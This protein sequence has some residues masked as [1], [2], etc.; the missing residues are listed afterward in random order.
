MKLIRFGEMGKEKPGVL[1]DDIRYDVSP[2]IQDYNENFFEND[3]MQQLQKIIAGHKNDLKLVDKNIRWGSPVVR[4]SKI[5][6]IGLNYVD[7]A[8][9]TNAPIP[10]E[11]IIFFKSS[12]A[13]CGP[14]DDLIIPKNST[15]TD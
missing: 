12:T 15:K 7:H 11:P 8:K 6:C 5:I 1:M 3:G 10:K 13:L 14:Y 2:F 4:P 9:E